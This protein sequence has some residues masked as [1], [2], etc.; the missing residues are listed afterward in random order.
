[1]AD[2]FYAICSNA[3]WGTPDWGGKGS[4]VARDA[5]YNG[6]YTSCATWESGRDGAA[7]GGDT[8]YGEIIGSWAADD[9]T[10]FVISGWDDTVTIILKT[11][12]VARHNGLWD[13]TTAHRLVASNGVAI[14]QPIES[15]VTLDGLQINNT[16]L[17][18]TSSRCIYYQ[19]ANTGMEISN[20]ILMTDGVGQGIELDESN[21]VIDIWNCLIY[22]TGGTVAD[23][24]IFSDFATTVN[25]YNCVIKHF[26][27]GVEQ[28]TGTVT[29]TNS[30]VYDNTDDF[31]GTIT[32]TNCASDDGDGSN[33][34]SGLTWTNEFTNPG[35]YDFSLKAG[36]SIKDAGVDDPGSGLYSNDIIGTAYTSTWP[37][38]AFEEVASGVVLAPLWYYYNR[39]RMG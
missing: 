24:G 23:A 37:I 21:L 38:G 3:Y 16:V 33:P 28:D 12:G 7:S 6:Q 34:Q 17:A 10:A 32:V 30:A 26:A 11:I 4:E 22:A 15:D 27:S 19:G 14:I 9:A 13:G 5:Y 20:C 29:I 25:I 35:I 18:D 2:V 31:E 8:E 36:N 39:Q 1:M